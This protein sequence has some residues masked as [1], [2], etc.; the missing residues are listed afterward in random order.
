MPKFAC[1]CGHVVNLSL[2]WDDAELLLVPQ[3]DV[4]RLGEGIDEGNVKSAEAAYEILDASSKAVYDCPK[5]HRLHMEVGR[6]TF[7]TY[8]REM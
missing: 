2:D 1:R 8:V 5:C 3:K 7:I 6:N 4:E